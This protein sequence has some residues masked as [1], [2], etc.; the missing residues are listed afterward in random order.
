MLQIHKSP[1][2]YFH[3]ITYL[4]ESIKNDAAEKSIVQSE[5]LFCNPSLMANFVVTPCYC[6][7]SAAPLAFV[8]RCLHGHTFT[9]VR[10][11]ELVNN[12]VDVDLCGRVVTCLIVSTDTQ[13][14]NFLCDLLCSYRPKIRRI[15]RLNR[16]ISSGRNGKYI[17]GTRRGCIKSSTVIGLF[18]RLEKASSHDH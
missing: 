3:N 9:Q 2:V 4:L 18:P 7:R 10:S 11:G 13:R 14:S 16:F 5:Y 12:F 8:C 15:I 17:V 1:Y 6:F